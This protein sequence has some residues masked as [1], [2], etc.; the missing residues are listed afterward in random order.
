MVTRT[1]VCREFA[2]KHGEP[3]QYRTM[4]EHSSPPALSY[5]FIFEVLAPNVLC[6]TAVI[7]RFWRPSA[8]H[9]DV[10]AA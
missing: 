9:L 8:D 1:R 6:V 3:I 2:R 5:A 7:N 4:D 10:M